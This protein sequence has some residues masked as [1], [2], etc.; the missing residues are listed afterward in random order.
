MTREQLQR[1]LGFGKAYTNRKIREGMP[2]TTV[3]DAKE[4]LE[5]HAKRGKPGVRSKAPN[6][7]AAVLLVEGSS[8]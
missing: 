8:T 7:A 1:E 4:W 3:E 2:T 5:E 6:P